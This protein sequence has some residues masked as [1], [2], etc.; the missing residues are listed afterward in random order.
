MRNAKEEFLSDSEMRDIEDIMAARYQ[1]NTEVCMNSSRVRML[2]QPNGRF[3]KRLRCVQ[4]NIV[5]N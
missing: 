2:S 3:L 1:L 4:V 5:L